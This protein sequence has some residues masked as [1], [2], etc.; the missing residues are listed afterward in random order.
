MSGASPTNAPG[1]SATSSLVSLAWR[2]SRS[3]RRRL[4]LYMSSISLGVAALVAIDSFAANINRSV[5]AQSRAL[6]G[7]DVSFS[8]RQGW[9]KGIDTLFDSLGATGVTLARETSFASMATAKAKGTTRLA[10]VRGVTDAYPLYGEVTTEPAGRWAALQQGRVALVDPSLLIALDVAVGD[11]LQLGYATFEIAGSLVNVPGDPGM[12]AAIGPRIYIADR[13]VADT[14]LLT[15]GSRADYEAFARLRP[16]V[17]AENWL[18][19]IRPRLDSARV[20]ART[21]SE[22]ETSLTESIDQLANFLGI[23]G[24]V[25]LLLGGVGVAS[26]VNA[27]VARKIDI[28]AVLRCVGATSRQVL[29]IYATQAAL[30]GLLGASIGALIGIAIQFALPGLLKGALPLDVQVQ[31]EPTAIATGIALGVW[32]ALAFALRPLVALRRISPLQA[33]RRNVNPPKALGFDWALWTVNLFIA[34]TVVGIS[35]TRANAPREVIGFS[36]GIAGVLVLLVLSAALLSRVARASVSARWPY[37]IRQGVANLYRPANQTRS[38]VL[39]LGFGAF[40]VTTLY[41]VQSN[42]LAQLRI[43]EEA[44]RGNLLFFD[45]QDDQGLGVDSIVRAA[46]IPVIQRTPIVTM[47]IALVN[48][49]TPDELA[50][51]RSADTLGEAQGGGAGGGARG[52][53]AQRPQGERRPAGW[54]LRR[55]YRSTFRDTLFTGETVLAGKWFGQTPAPT[56]KP[57]DEVSLE[58][59]IADDL[60]VALGDVITWDVQGVRIPTRVTSIREVNWARFEPNFYAVFQSKTLAQAPKTFVLLGAATDPRLTAQVQSAV[61]RRYPNVASIDLSLVRK[62]VGEISRRASLAIRFLAIF[63]LAMGIPVLFSAVAA[64]RRERVRE[65]VLLKT[66]GATRAQIGRI[67]VSEYTVLGV[68]GS[69]TGLVLSFGGAWAIMRYVFDRPFTAA[70]AQAL[71]ISA[72]MMGMAVLIGMLSGRDVFKETAMTALREN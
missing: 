62:T 10:Q 26:G 4:L 9:T 71:G 41:L 57:A 32:I 38:V 2:E 34:A 36:A 47:R 30:M 33:I 50:P 35:A 12:A 29:L 67:L 72:A 70:T 56:G 18:K 8:A 58:S 6:V 64:T 60:N 1:G 16:W 27:W 63:S 15:F 7:G 23:V 3:T 40:L 20:R 59:D 52:R 69:L 49:K 55:E 14:K 66:L 54:A 39:S 48:G 53:N 13:H 24:I 51:R 21:V 5:R 44:S 61:V 68:L 65:G 43:T 25:A 19:A 42:L 31:V 11:S 45:V 17:D 37:V 28:V 46:G 22:S